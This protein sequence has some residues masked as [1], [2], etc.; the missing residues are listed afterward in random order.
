MSRFLVFTFIGLL[1]GSPGPAVA[2]SADLSG[3]PVARHA[4][5]H[6]IEAH[7]KYAV[8]WWY[9]TG[10]LRLAGAPRAFGFEGT[11]FRFDT[12]YRH[13]PNLPRSAWE[14]ATVLSFH[15]AISDFSKKRFVWRET[16]GRRFRNS[17]SLR[18]KPFAI[19]LNGNRLEFTGDSR[20]FSL[21]LSEEVSGVLLDLDL[22]GS[23][24][25]LWQDP[26]GTLRTGPGKKDWAYYYSHPSLTVTGRMGKVGKRNDIRWRVV[27]GKAWL[28]HEWTHQL[29]GSKQ[30]GWIWLGARL[31]EGG[32]LMIFQM[33]EHGHPDEFRGGTYRAGKAGPVQWL[34]SSAVTIVPVRYWKSPQTGICYPSLIR[35]SIGASGRGF[36]IRPRFD[37]QELTGSVPYWEGAVQLEDPVTKGFRGEGYL[38]LT[39]YDKA[40]RGSCPG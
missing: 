21:H 1:L 27:S 29:M 23:E 19:A 40:D 26:S 10:H 28:D 39:G 22:S 13:P 3:S 37:G 30:T 18:E 7:P 12:G 14:P 34:R 35:V 5:G 11:F 33:E 25:P 38:E 16:V 20:R 4:P 15:G 17:A 31:P 32:A 24:P 9:V 8:E 2:S 6:L 36:L